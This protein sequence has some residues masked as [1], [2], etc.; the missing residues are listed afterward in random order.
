MRSRKIV[1]DTLILPG[2]TIY[3]TLHINSV[4]HDTIHVRDTV[5]VAVTL[6][7]KGTVTDSRKASCEIRPGWMLTR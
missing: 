7:D 5:I 1:I 6:I 2:K 4:T 3:D